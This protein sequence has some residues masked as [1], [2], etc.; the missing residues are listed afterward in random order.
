CS[1]EAIAGRGRPATYRDRLQRQRAAAVDLLLDQASAH[2]RLAQ[3]DPEKALLEQAVAA[4]AELGDAVRHARALLALG[5]VE[6]RMNQVAAA[7]QS[8]ERAALLAAAAHDDETTAE[9]A[10]EM[11]SLVNQEKLSGAEIELRERTL[12]RELARRPD[13]ALLARF[14]LQRGMLAHDRGDLD[15]ALAHA[16]KGLALA[17]RAHGAGNPRIAQAL[18][19]IGGIRTMRG[20]HAGAAVALQRAVQ[21]V[22]SSYGPDHPDVAAGLSL[23]ARAVAEGGDPS[24]AVELLRRSL[25]IREKVF[26]PEHPDV[27]QS[28]GNLATALELTGDLAGARRAYERSIAVEEKTLGERSWE[29]APS[30]ASL[31]GVLAAQGDAGARAMYERAIAIYR[32][33]FPPDYPDQTVPLAGLGHLLRRAGDC[34]QAAPHLTRALAIHQVHKS[35]P[36]PELVADATAC[37]AV[38]F[39]PRRRSSR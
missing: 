17:E 6:M 21:L 34:R 25:A 27:A 24:R 9:A 7:R 16:E 26:G 22:E 35:E 31:A 10:A 32:D 39:S 37:K 13:P 30:I 29:S 36:P 14:E 4:A 3:L 20:D 15:T 12:E 8:L 28:L 5:I 23:L 11:L 38:A 18:R 33:K 19:F 1:A 2:H